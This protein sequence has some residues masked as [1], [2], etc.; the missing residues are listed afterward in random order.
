MFGNLPSF[1]VSLKRRDLRGRIRAGFYC[2]L[3]VSLAAFAAPARSQ[4]VRAQVALGPFTPHGIGL[5]PVTNKIYVA[6][7][8]GNLGVVDGATGVQ[9]PASGGSTTYW[10]VAVD[11]THNLVYALDRTNQNVDIFAGATAGSGAVF[12]TSVNL[13]GT[14][15]NFF[16]IAVNPVNGKVY[17]ANDGGGVGLYIVDTQNNNSIT[18]LATGAATVAVAVDPSTGMA[19]T[20]ANTTPTV[21]QLCVISPTD[22]IAATVSIPGSAQALAVNS[23]TNRAYVA[24]SGSPGSVFAIDSTN[25]IVNTFS[26]A[27]MVNPSSLAVNP[28]TDQIYVADSGSN[29][30]SVIHDTGSSNSLTDVSQSSSG[31]A[32]AVDASSNVAYVANGSGSTVTVVNGTSLTAQVVP[33][34]GASSALIQAA[35]N[36][37]TH[38]GYVLNDSGQALYDIDGATYSQ[39]S[40]ST[41][42]TPYAIAVNPATNKIY[43]ANITQNNVDVLDDNVADCVAI[44]EPTPCNVA[45]VTVGNSPKALVVDAINNLVYV[46]DEGDSTV[47]II[48]GADNSTQTVMIL[49]DSNNPTVAPDSIAYNPVLNLVVGASS[50]GNW[51]FAFPGGFPG[52]PETINANNF[53]EEFGSQDPVAVAV[54]P[55]N[56]LFYTLFHV[57]QSLFI[58]QGVTPFSGN[59]VFPCNGANAMDVNVATDTVY[60]AC[61]DGTTGSVTADVGSNGFNGGSLPSIIN[62]GGAIPVA[63]AVNPVT[64]LIY[65]IDHA[66]ASVYVIDG[67]SNTKI[68]TITVGTSPIAVAV[69]PVS[70]KIYVLNQGTAGDATVSVIDGVMNTVLYTSP[71]TTSSGS[72]DSGISQLAVN[73]ATSNIFAINLAPGSNID[74]VEN[75]TQP[76]AIQTTIAP[77]PVIAGLP[78]NATNTVSPAFSFSA[79]NTLTPAHNI[80]WLFYQVDTQTGEWT[81]A[82][83]ASPGFSGVLTN[84]TPGFHTLYAFATDGE[85]SSADSAPLA[86]QAS[87][88]VGSVAAY[89][90]LVD[91]PLA[92][93][94]VFPGPG[95]N[96]AIGSTSL[97]NPVL[98]NPG[99][100]PLNYSYQITGPNAADFVA[101]PTYGNS[102]FTNCAAPSGTLAPDSICAV[103]I[104]FSPSGVGAETATLTFT[105]NA[106]GAGH[107]VQTVGLVGNG[108]PATFFSGLTNSQSISAGTAT[109]SLS[110]TI[111]NAPANFPPNGETVSITINGVPQ[112]ASIGAN[113]SFSATFPTATIPASGTPYPIT[114]SYAGD[115]NFGSASDSSTTLTVTST[116][117][118]EPATVSLLGT[119]SGGVAATIGIINNC[120]EMNGISTGTCSDTYF[121]NGPG[122]TFT[123]TADGTTTFGGWGGDCVSF[124]TNTQCML[125]TTSPI[126]VTANFVAPAVTTT[127]NFPT[128]TNVSNMATF[129]CPSNPNPSPTSPCLDPNAH[130]FALAID[131]VTQPF[132][133]TLLATEFSPTNGNADGICPASSSLINPM[134]FDCR[135]AEFFTGATQG[136]GDRVVP[137]CDPY[138]NGNCVHYTVYL[139]SKGNEPD[140]TMFSG[141]VNW[142]VSW[143]NDLFI[144]PAPYTGTNP[145]LY[146]DPDG[147]TGSPTPYGT[148]CTQQMLVGSGTQEPYSCQFEFDI[149]T[150]FDPTKK[151]DATIGGK[152]KQFSDVIVAFP[153]AEFT[154][155]TASQTITAG[156]TSVTLGGFVGLESKFPLA[157]ESVSITID[158]FTQLATITGNNGA[159]STSFNTAGIAT[160]GTPYMITYSYLGDSNLGVA[161]D[162]STTLTVNPGSLTDTTMTLASSP[163]SPVPY[164]DPITITA[165]VDPSGAVPTGSVQ[166]VVDGVNLGTPVVIVAGGS[167]GACAQGAACATSSPITALGTGLHTITA[168]YLPT[169]NFAGSVATL[170][171]GLSVLRT[172]TTAVGLSPTAVTVGGG[173][174][175][176][177][178]VTDTNGPPVFNPAGTI[179]LTSSDTGGS[180]DTFSACTLSTGTNP[181]T[182]TAT[183]TTHE[184]GTSPH[185]ITATYSPTD[186]I[187]SGGNGSSPL[188]V[189]AAAKA[190][191]VVTVSSSLTPSVFGQS[192]AL[193]AT[194]T[195]PAPG[196][197]LPAPGESVTFKDGSSTLGVAT[198]L[199]NGTATLNTSSL[200]VAGHSITAVYPGDTLYLGNTS[201]PFMQTVNKASTTTKITSSLATATTVGQAYSVAYSVTVNAPGGGSIAGT[202][203]VTVSDGSAICTA[204]VTAGTCQLTSTTPG[205]KTVTATFA[206]DSSYVSSASTGVS[207]TVNQ[208]PTITS[209]NSTTFTQGTFGNFPVTATGFPSTFTFSFSGTLPT[210]VTLSSAGVLSGAP[211][212]SGSFPITITASNGIS[213]SGTQSFTLKVNPSATSALK[214]SPPT[215][216][217]GTVYAGSFTLRTTTIT[218]TGN[219]MV[220]FTNF[221]V[222]SISGND[223]TGFIGVDFCP[224]TLSAGKSCTVI[225]SFTAD[226]NV[227]KTHAANLVVAD[228]ASGS[229]QIVPMT[230]TVINPGASVSPSSISFGTEKVNSTTTKPVTLTNSGTTTLNISKIAIT[231]SNIADFSQTNNCGTSLT[232]G[233]HCTIT[234]TFKPV[235]K[236]SFSANLT[237][238]DNTASG[239]QNVS[240][241][242]KGN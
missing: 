218:N 94:N 107:V 114:Y 37:V 76:V 181:V 162:T 223:S 178:T 67:S 47:T 96:T 179:A 97:F 198:T 150:T 184:I 213:P 207:H 172:T 211:T 40:V 239:T 69:N 212:A 202:D 139:G 56:G 152:T 52:S 21:N 51:G 36:P 7:L 204:T 31:L 132:T 160:S 58:S 95:G 106:F 88:V 85:D 237:I 229:P 29:F 35:A 43:V 89:T 45:T 175:V 177:V 158:G 146:E 16:A 117:T 222:A 122:V 113:G 100:S 4:T 93:T 153:P 38:H 233:S 90:F 42:N 92:V 99:G 147:V 144:P 192:V 227:T 240:L 79:V 108:V 71:V 75:V 231:G 18:T 11:S 15:G 54:N 188:T 208:A 23:S 72:E 119:G 109:I 145:R 205:V 57:N 143:N 127:L 138:A 129:D 203:S 33:L 2:L 154:N 193:T 224:K 103:N 166:F 13:T 189:N 232:A 70:N 64:N 195:V 91:P 8:N 163:A 173:S 235:S 221:S 39:A 241:S 142:T 55:A 159:F 124:G 157:G 12:Q 210:G 82:T 116:G 20:I 155:L 118:P 10:D 105:D 32:V 27:N 176:T 230:A 98:I 194:I 123:E 28:A 110:G 133:L 1:S 115:P 136:N 220:T 6:N 216:A 102:A 134:D 199:A 236:S 30:T 131:Q 209:A 164:G 197:G 130:S 169:N 5:N 86:G 225:M 77:L 149:T 125:P 48:N 242:G 186:G 63:V 201:A 87:P 185:T 148:D 46:A 26:N 156:T 128:G 215:L 135:F 3:L 174:T 238:S 190:A 61:Y 59:L 196:T 137:L 60:M 182:C 214:F 73:P 226:S 180:G 34:G 168:S 83:Q 25:A 50:A 217:F 80:A 17:V 141:D 187:H 62:I 68:K 183:V 104:F 151:V 228:N 200:S 49:D 170:G 120:H 41:S 219:A 191:T 126:N 101:N 66:N 44:S 121:S 22:T 19:Y 171:G 81:R 78:A 165:T 74:L 84:L 65:V 234:V 14:Q 111:E 206:G 161:T 9:S 140:S 112:N 53:D 167:T 24:V